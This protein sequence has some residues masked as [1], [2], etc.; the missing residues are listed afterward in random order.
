[1]FADGTKWASLVHYIETKIYE[2]CHINVTVE[3]LANVRGAVRTFL[4]ASGVW[5]EDLPVGGATWPRLNINGNDY[6]ASHFNDL[7]KKISWT[8][9]ELVRTKGSG[10]DVKILFLLGGFAVTGDG[11]TKHHTPRRMLPYTPSRP[12]A[13]PGTH[14]TPRRP[15][16]VAA[17]LRQALARPAHFFFFLFLGNHHG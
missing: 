12:A 15:M 6:G 3:E 14:K 11:Y 4:K 7:K 16:S 1:M 13:T 8:Y 5:Q 2:D 9:E 17:R 10:L